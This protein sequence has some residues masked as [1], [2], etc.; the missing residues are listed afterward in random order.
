LESI[1][2]GILEQAAPRAGLD[3]RHE[4]SLLLCDGPAM[5]ALNR[6]W[7]AIDGSTNVLS[8]PQRPARPGQSLE[9]GPVGDVVVALPV[10]RREARRTGMALEAHLARLLVHG[11]LHLLGY[12]HERPGEAERM[13]E[14]E[15]EILDRIATP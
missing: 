15:R 4:I 5:R 2:R 13:A 1:C 7:R 6:R 11:L 3:A 8:F 12:D 10:A 9:A 14:K